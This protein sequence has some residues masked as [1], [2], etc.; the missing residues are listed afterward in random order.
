MKSWIMKKRI[1]LSGEFHVTGLPLIQ[2]DTLHALL[3]AYRGDQLKWW[4]CNEQLTIVWSEGELLNPTLRKVIL[5]GHQNI[6][7]L[8]MSLPPSMRMLLLLNF[9]VVTAYSSHDHCFVATPPKIEQHATPPIPETHV[10]CNSGF[11]LGLCCIFITTWFHCCPYRP[12]EWSGRTKS[13]LF[14]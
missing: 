6:S 5:F 12:R 2:D 7:T 4:G 11:P 3:H 14:S 8:S 13:K 9:K 10:I 1:Q